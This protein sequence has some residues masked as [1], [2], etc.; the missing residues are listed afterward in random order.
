MLRFPL[1]PI[2]TLL[3][4]HFRKW[5]I[6]LLLIPQNKKTAFIWRFQ[7]SLMVGYSGFEPLT[8]SMSRKR[9]NQLS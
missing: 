5:R 2:L 3:L 9:S 1:C 7:Q 8:S 6:T 4:P